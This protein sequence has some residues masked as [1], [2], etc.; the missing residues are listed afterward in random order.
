MRI[1]LPNLKNGKTNFMLF[2]RVDK[3]KKRII[4]PPR[5]INIKALKNQTEISLYITILNK[6]AI[7]TRY[8]HKIK[9][10]LM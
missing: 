1:A 10:F 9:G 3:Y 7:S 4:I 5:K 6:V 8:R 2:E